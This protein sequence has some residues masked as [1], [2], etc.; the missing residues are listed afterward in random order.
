MEP[1]WARLFLSETYSVDQDS[2]MIVLKGPFLL[3]V[4]CEALRDT[5][6]LRHLSRPPLRPFWSFLSYA[7]AIA[8]DW[9]AFYAMDNIFWII[10]LHSFTFWHK[11]FPILLEI[12]WT[13]WKEGW[14]I[15]QVHHGKTGQHG[16]PL[17]ALRC[18]PWYSTGSLDR[19]PRG[20]LERLQLPPRMSSPT[21]PALLR[22]AMDLLWRPLHQFGALGLQAT[23]TSL[24]LP[25]SEP[26]TS[27]LPIQ[28]PFCGQKRPSSLARTRLPKSLW[29][30]ARPYAHTLKYCI[31][32]G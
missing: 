31:V 3:C 8:M 13:L 12:I 9:I 15:R 22:T 32:T 20:S 1:P 7:L 27:P 14:L 6:R 5:H 29:S 2:V 30:L 18:G 24:Y 26:Q 10:Y 23:C 16:A 21:L 4:Y 19:L 28:R 11:L 17:L 25:K